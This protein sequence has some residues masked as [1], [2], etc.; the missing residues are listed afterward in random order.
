MNLPIKYKV[1]IV[2]SWV[3][4]DEENNRF[5]LPHSM[6]WISLKPERLTQFGNNLVGA[7]NVSKNQFTWTWWMPWI[8]KTCPPNA[9][10]LISKKIYIKKDNFC[11][12]EGQFYATF[13]TVVPTSLIKILYFAIFP[14][15][16]EFNIILRLL[17]NP[18]PGTFSTFYD[19]L[20]QAIHN[21]E[22]FSVWL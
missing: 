13:E 22:L 7:I 15:W 6:F 10:G 12:V 21:Y 18:T 9:N 4:F 8:W 19:M 3:I 16:W 20:V 1:L 17:S 5:C 11:V 2:F 14:L